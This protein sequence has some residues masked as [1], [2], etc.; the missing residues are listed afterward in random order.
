MHT[1]EHTCPYT[2]ACAYTLTHTL[3]RLYILD[4]GGI[5]KTNLLVI[6]YIHSLVIECIIHYCIQFNVGTYTHMHTHKHIYTC[7]SRHIHA[8]AHI[9]T[10]THVR[11]YTHIYIYTY[12]TMKLYILY[13]FRMNLLK[14]I[15]LN[16]C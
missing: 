1:R 15:S 7:T 14:N 9:C 16:V 5:F 10:Y 6:Y 2:H 3:M 4:I 12:T 13:I 11:T 8:C